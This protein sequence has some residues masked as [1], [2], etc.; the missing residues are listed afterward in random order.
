MMMAAP[1]AGVQGQADQAAQRQEQFE[2]FYAENS[3][4]VLRQLLAVTGSV[5]EAQ[6]CVQEA[7]ARAWQRWASL[8]Q[9][10]N[11]QAWVR[12]V[13]YRC[14]VSRWRKARNRIEAHFREAYRPPEP[15]LTPEVV[16]LMA[17][18]REL[19]QH[20]REVIALFHLADLPLEEVAHTLD[21]P[22]NTVKTRLSRGREALRKT[23]DDAPTPASAGQDTDHGGGRS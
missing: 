7:F 5:A 3:A 1:T 15:D 2:A 13:A 18:L 9:H 22:L 8:A 4:A 6:D 17:A 12:Q 10:P 20:Q 16:A 11:P 19:P 21:V 14:A 23:L